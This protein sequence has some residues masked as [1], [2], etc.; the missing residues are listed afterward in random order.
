MRDLFLP[1]S[2]V[3]MCG[4][5][6][7]PAVH[8]ERR[9]RHH[10]RRLHIG[11]MPP[12]VC[13]NRIECSARHT[14]STI[15]CAALCHAYH[16]IVDTECCACVDNT[17]FVSGDMFHRRRD[18]SI[19]VVPTGPRAVRQEDPTIVPY[20]EGTQNRHIR[21]NHTRG[22]RTFSGLVRRDNMDRSCVPV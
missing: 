8:S 20:R 14:G 19:W 9:L 6:R 17:D 21:R 16:H 2:A 15:D 13:T 22:T 5:R 11:D 1:I 4:T 3:S 18:I 10:H 7:I 12:S